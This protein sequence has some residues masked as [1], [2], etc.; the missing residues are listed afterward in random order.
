M[1]ST[2]SSIFVRLFELCDINVVKAYENIL[3]Q[4][5]RI[6]FTI[7]VI[8]FGNNTTISVGAGSEEE[9]RMTHFFTRPKNSE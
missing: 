6:S 7:F 2:I 1:A 4:I 5:D 8:Y 3:I 9:S